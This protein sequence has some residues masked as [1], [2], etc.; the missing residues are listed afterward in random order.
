M[1]TVQDAVTAL[2]GIPHPGQGSQKYLLVEEALLGAG[3]LHP[4]VEVE[5]A[6]P[7]FCP[8]CR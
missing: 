5:P 8:F 6:K 3:I 4:Q 7:G 2:M 1:Q